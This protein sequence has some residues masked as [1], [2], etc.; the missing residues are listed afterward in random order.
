MD[1]NPFDIAAILAKKFKM[2]SISEREET[3]LSNWLAEN[4]KNQLLF[5]ELMAQGGAFQSHWLDRI[6]DEAAWAAVQRRLDRKRRKISWRAVAASIV[7][8]LSAG[9]FWL[10]LDQ[11]E[12]GNP[13]YVKSEVSKYANDVLPADMGAKII[14]AGGKELRVSDTLRINRD[15]QIA[16]NG[17]ESSVAMDEPREVFHTLVVPAA[18]FFKITLSDGTAVWVN[19]NSELRFPARFDGTERRVHL[20]GEAYFEVAKDKAKPFYV[21]TKDMQVRVLG[22]HFN[23]SAYGENSRTSLVEGS[24]E[25]TTEERNVVIVP[26]QSAEWS[27]GKL[28]VKRADFQK[29]LAWKNNE[30]YFHEDNIL[31]I[32]HQ[33][34]R[35]YDL[36]ITLSRDVSL[37]ETYSG[38]IR[39]DVRLSEVLKMLEFVSDLDF[40]LTENKLLIRKK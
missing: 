2:E 22:T 25:V 6:D 33:L 12:T 27:N 26:G 24:V 23:V 31:N 5:D 3:V 8:L 11:Q 9:L 37:T 32:A 14:L 39:R 10:S 36:D 35:W 15:G 17:I 40:K 29:D 20:T 1:T 4:P 7:V 34:K 21:E 16:V 18:N 28:R 13:R 19:S 30:F 38:G